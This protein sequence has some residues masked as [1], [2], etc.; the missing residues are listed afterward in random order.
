M[1]HLD[2]ANQQTLLRYRLKK[3]TV[4]TFI[5]AYK[6]DSSCTYK[7]LQLQQQI[8][9]LFLGNISAFPNL[10]NHRSCSLRLHLLQNVWQIRRS[11]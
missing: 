11:K 6:H 1:Q 10:E 3:T 2:I 8:F 4:I 7:T 5:T 9:R